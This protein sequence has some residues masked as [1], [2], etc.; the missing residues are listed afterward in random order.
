MKNSVGEKLKTERPLRCLCDTGSLDSIM[1]RQAV[2]KFQNVKFEK[3]K[4][5]WKTVGGDYHT[6]ESASLDFKLS[7]FSETQEIQWKFH[8]SD[9][10]VHE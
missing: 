3:E 9:D 6:S 1:L 5:T 2:A 10:K 8:I 7:D 4:T